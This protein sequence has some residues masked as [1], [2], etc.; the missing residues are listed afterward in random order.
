MWRSSWK[1]TLWCKN[2]KNELFI[3]CCSPNLDLSTGACCASIH[4]L[5]PIIFISGN[6]LITSRQ[7]QCLHWAQNNLRTSFL[8]YTLVNVSVHIYNSLKIGVVLLP[9]NILRTI[10]N[11]QLPVYS[12]VFALLYVLHIWQMAANGSMD[13]GPYLRK[14]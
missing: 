11:T 10:V 6:E 8:P 2:T 7:I 9:T 3:S 14:Y 1:L 12:P 13:K 5:F 4:A